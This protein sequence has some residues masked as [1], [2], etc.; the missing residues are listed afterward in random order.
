MYVPCMKSLI[1]LAHVWL[2]GLLGLAIKEFLF[3]YNMD[4]SGFTA[5]QRTLL[6]IKYL[7]HLKKIS[8][9][10]RNALNL[11]RNKYI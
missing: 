4:G 3:P 6:E 7:K 10:E 2:L 1:V 8:Y 9:A 11:N 5:Q